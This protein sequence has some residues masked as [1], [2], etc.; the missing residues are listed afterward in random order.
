MGT[1]RNQYGFPKIVIYLKFLHSNPGQHPYGDRRQELVFIGALE[2][3][4]VRKILDDAL[5]TEEEYA[6]GPETWTSWKKLIS[7]EIL[8]PEDR[9]YHEYSYYYSYYYF[10]YYYY[11]Y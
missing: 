10:Y 5:V 4:S 1:C 2:E 3:E 11:Y 9:Y 8:R 6:L 7:T